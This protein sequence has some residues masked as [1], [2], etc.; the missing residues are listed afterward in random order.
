MT[1]GTS[2]GLRPTLAYTLRA[3]DD[4]RYSMGLRQTLASTVRAK[5]DHR[6]F[7]GTQADPSLYAKG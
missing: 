5:D 2:L 3:K 7:S 1:V 6:Y 4:R